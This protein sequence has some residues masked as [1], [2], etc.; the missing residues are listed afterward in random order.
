LSYTTFSYGKPVLS[1]PTLTA[2]KAITAS[3]T[4]TNTGNY[5]GEEV[6]QLYIK[7]EVGSI[8]RP[9]KELKGFQ[10]IFLKKGESK[11]ITFS[12]DEKTLRFYNAD[13]KH[14]SEKGSFQ[15]YIGSNAAVENGVSFQLK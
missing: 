15:L 1:A 3:V 14:I 2:A 7:D 13:L 12:I 11:T 10:K 5:D 6:V 9:L 8:T 4:L